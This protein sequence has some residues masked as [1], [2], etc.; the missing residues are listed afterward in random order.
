MN[1]GHAVKGRL[2]SNLTGRAYTLVAS[3]RSRSFTSRALRTPMSETGQRH[4]APGSTHRSA[5][6]TASA[7]LGVGPTCIVVTGAVL[8]GCIEGG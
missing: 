6:P 5:E 8:P 7:A 3:R 2:W 1:R 4:Q